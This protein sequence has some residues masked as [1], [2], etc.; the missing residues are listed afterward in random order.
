LPPTN[1]QI[2]AAIATAD[3]ALGYTRAVEG[4]PP[5]HVN[6]VPPAADGQAFTDEDV[7]AWSKS[8]GFAATA[9]LGRVSTAK[10]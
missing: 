5:A 9:K 7:A 2:R 6:P 3:R 10:D 8:L 4:Q 1:D